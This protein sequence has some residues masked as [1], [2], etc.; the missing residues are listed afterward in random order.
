MLELSSV[1]EYGTNLCTSH[2]ADPSLLETN[3]L[4]I[5]I[6]CFSTDVGASCAIMGGLMGQEIVKSIARKSRPLQNVFL[7]DAMCQVGRGGM[8]TTIVPPSLK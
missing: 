2:H 1:Q 8:Q 5:M 7:L 4:E 3:V 6:N